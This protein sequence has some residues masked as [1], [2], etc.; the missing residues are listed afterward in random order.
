MFQKSATNTLQT[1][2]CQSR[3]SSTGA[4]TDPVKPAAVCSKECTQTGDSSKK[5][6]RS[7]TSRSKSS[8]ESAKQTVKQKPVSKRTAEPTAHTAKRTRHGDEDTSNPPCLYCHELFATSKSR[9]KWIKCTACLKWAHNACAGI[10]SK[11]SSFVC[12]LCG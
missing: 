5:Y 7:Q 9:E 10:S 12:D 8:C 3:Q 2:P 1:A 6:K 11:Q 4:E